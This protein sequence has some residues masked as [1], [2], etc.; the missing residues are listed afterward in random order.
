MQVRPEQ[1]SVRHHFF[2]YIN[3]RKEKEYVAGNSNEVNI[4]KSESFF[5]RFFNCGQIAG[6]QENFMLIMMLILNSHL[7]AKNLNI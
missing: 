6:T 7:I 5:C 1:N 3:E 4:V 2:Q